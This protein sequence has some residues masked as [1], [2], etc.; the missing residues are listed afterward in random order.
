V[1][2]YGRA[3][4]PE[5][6]RFSSSGGPLPSRQVIPTGKLD[7]PAGESLSNESQF[8]YLLDPAESGAAMGV[9]ASYRRGGQ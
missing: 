5:K 6:G 3:R 9:S 8:V 4:R 1:A 2:R 7:L